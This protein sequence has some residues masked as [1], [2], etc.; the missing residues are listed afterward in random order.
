MKRVA[1]RM[2]LL[3]GHEAEYKK[4]HDEIWPDLAELLK[5]EGISDYAIYLDRSTLS[6]FGVLKIPDTKNLDNL[7]GKAV[8]Q[9]W[10]AYMADIMET[11]SDHSPVNI[12]LEEVFY[13]S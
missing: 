8:M 13:L 2:K 4:R 7:P 6:L 9:R 3:P 1:F 5:N 11:N 10:W 12:P